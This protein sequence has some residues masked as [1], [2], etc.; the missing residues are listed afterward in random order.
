MGE[1]VNDIERRLSYSVRQRQHLRQ[2]TPLSGRT[3]QFAVPQQ[4]CVCFE[5]STGML[6]TLTPPFILTNHT[7]LDC[8]A[9][10]NLFTPVFCRLALQGWHSAC[11]LKLECRNVRHLLRTNPESKAGENTGKKKWTEC[12]VQGEEEKKQK[13]KK[14]NVSKRRG[15][16]RENKKATE[17]AQREEAR[18]NCWGWIRI[19]ATL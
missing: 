5:A 6:H 9:N 11:H 15:M 16:G 2:E 4:V 17:E 1:A 10:G 8:A 18:A 12:D 3:L 19:R 7:M 13:E 14:S